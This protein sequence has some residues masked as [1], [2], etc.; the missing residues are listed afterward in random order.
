MNNLSTCGWKPS[1]NISQ[2]VVALTTFMKNF[3]HLWWSPGAEKYFGGTTLAI[4]VPL[5]T[6]TTALVS[7]ISA[8]TY[9]V[10]N[11]QQRFKNI[12]CSYMAWM[13]L[14]QKNSSLSCMVE[15]ETVSVTSLIWVTIAVWLSK[16]LPSCKLGAVEML[17]LSK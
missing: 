8:V 15:E 14:R 12:I 5:F 4:Q 3:S 16:L 9:T 10:F 17:F 7:Q 1:K 13:L 11:L 2:G 6:S